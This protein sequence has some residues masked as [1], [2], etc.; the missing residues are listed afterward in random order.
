ML[1]LLDDWCEVG[2]RAYEALESTVV[3]LDVFARFF[4]G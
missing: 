1:F 2:T 3:I 4:G